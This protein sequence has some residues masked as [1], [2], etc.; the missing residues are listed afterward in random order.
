[1]TKSTITREPITHDL[2][3]YP[4]FFSAVCT[5]V[6]RAE[7]RKNDRDY[8]VGDTLHL[9][10]TPRG[11]CHRTGEYIN[12]TIT[13]IADVGEWM[14]GYVLLSVEIQ[15]RRKAAMDSEHKRNPVLAYADSYRDM[16]KQGV[17]SVPIWSVIT[18]LERNIAPLYRHAQPAPVVPDEI[19][20]RIGGLDWGWEG[21]FNRGWN[22]CR[23]AMLQAGTLTNENTRQ[24]DELTMWIKRLVRS[25]KNANPDSKL[26]RDAMDYLTAKGLISLGDVLR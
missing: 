18:D 13:H 21:E 16:A 24:V 1:M 14:P 10:E 19:K 11:S 9:M 26:P 20:H 2:K 6:K 22:A 3:I 23:A 4:E 5:G 7:L 25:L 15:G 12:V 8:L 17:E